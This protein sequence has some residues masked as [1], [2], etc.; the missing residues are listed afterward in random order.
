MTINSK[1][2]PII[3]ELQEDQAFAKQQAELDVLKAHLNELTPDLKNGTGVIFSLSAAELRVAA[4]I[5]NGLTS[6]EIARTLNLSFDTVKTH[7]KNIR[8]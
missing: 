7:R 8:K 1:V 5:K 2:L 3:E 4:M 6:P